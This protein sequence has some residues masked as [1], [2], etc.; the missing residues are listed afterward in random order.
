MSTARR[1]AREMAV[2]ETNA[3]ALGATLEGLMESTGRAVAEEAMRHLP[4]PPARAA[5]VA[6][7][8]NNGGDGLC[9]AYYL[10]QWGYSPE[11]WMVRPPAEIRSPATRRC[12]DR[13]AQHAPVHSGVPA[14][15]VLREFPLVLDALLGTGQSGPLRPPYSEA[16]SA[17]MTSGAPVLSIDLPSGLGAE[18]AVRPRW[19]VTLT[20]EKEG[21]EEANSGEIA[22]RDIGIPEAAKVETGPGEFHLYPIPGPSG[23]NARVIVI[24]GGP[25]AG[26][27]ALT[28]LAALRSGAERATVFAPA[29]VSTVIQGFSPDLVVEAAGTDRFRPEDAPTLLALLGSQRHDA[30]AVGM[31]AG[32][33]AAT[34]ECLAGVLRVVPPHTPCLVDADALES[35]LAAWASP[36]GGRSA[37]LTPNAGEFLRLTGLPGT[38]GRPEREDAARGLTRRFGGAVLAKGDPDLLVDGERSYTNL[39]HHPAATVAGVGDIL[40]GV[41]VS[42][43]AQG[44]APLPASRLGS[45]WVGEAGH[46]AFE[47]RAYGL[48]A[49]DVLEEL[50]GALADGLRRLRA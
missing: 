37:V 30:L 19:T 38:P 41:V 14:P 34:V 50:P 23:R 43:L 7:P 12:Y 25:F 40:S 16:S 35:A 18:G 31:G 11:V 39:H 42:L 6:G 44:L 3:L 48:T 2:L 1:S 17:I 10:A 47:R 8:G 32:R 24:G 49:S 46:R 5:I 33:D 28:A 13:I 15:E 4:P 27:P 20:C 36:A 45:Y 21:M 29:K 9:A 22:V 26:A